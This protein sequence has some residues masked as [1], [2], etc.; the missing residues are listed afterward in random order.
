ME[1]YIIMFTGEFVKFCPIQNR[2]VENAFFKKKV[3]KRGGSK[4]VSVSLFIF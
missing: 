3:Q 4:F 2:E 1:M